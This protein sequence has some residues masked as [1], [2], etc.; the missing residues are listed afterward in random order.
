ME[1]LKTQ[2]LNVSVWHNDNFGRNNFLGELELDLTEWDFN[3]TQIN[4][5]T[6]KPRVGCERGSVL[7]KTRC[8]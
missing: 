3:N 6:L 8:L 4:E 1:T 7:L 2:K 5:Y